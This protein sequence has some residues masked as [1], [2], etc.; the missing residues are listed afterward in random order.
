MM[1]TNSPSFHKYKDEETKSDY[2]NPKVGK[3]SKIDTYGS[4]KRD[5]VLNDK[6][7]LMEGYARDGAT[8]KQIAEA[9]GISQNTLINMKSQYGDVSEALRK[10]KEIVDYA[11]ENALLRK[12]LG[13]DVTA[14][15][16][17]LRN[18]KPDKWRD[19]KE[20]NANLQDGFVN[21]DFSGI[22]AKLGEKNHLELE[23]DNNANNSREKSST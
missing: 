7:L 4:W 20:L 13:G 18:R 21:L 11:V 6:L 3:G 8:E 14:I 23:V 22:V 17:W 5:G 15:T 1:S 2:H 12:A 19:I 16:F 10:G 9:L